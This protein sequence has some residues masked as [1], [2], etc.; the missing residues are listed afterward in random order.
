MDDPDWKAIYAK[1]EGVERLFSRLK[2]H[3]RINSITVRGLSRVTAHCYVPMIV[4]N[5]MA[6]AMPETPRQVVRAA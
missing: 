5:A 6:L 1:R 3:R 4:M 2:L